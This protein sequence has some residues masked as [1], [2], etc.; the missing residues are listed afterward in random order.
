MKPRQTEISMNSVRRETL[1]Q[2]VMDQIIEL[3]T[4]GQLKPG[5]KLPTEAELTELF[6][7]S[8]PVLREAL[9]SLETMGIIQRKTREGT[10]LADKIGSEPFSIMLAI[11]IGDTQSILEA[12]MALEL[13]LVTLAADKITDKQLAELEK[14]LD[15]TAKNPADYLQFD[16]QFHSLI[17]YSANNPA[18][19]GLV[20][21]LLRI[22]D[23]TLKLVPPI[24]R[25]YA[26]TLEQH[27]EILSALKNRDPIAAYR[28]MFHHLNYVRVK[29]VN[30]L[31]RGS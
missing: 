13:G 16:R 14:C 22:F 3:L 15:L 10:F 19:E 28:S 26:V 9:S 4:H 7:V 27:Y 1:S 24:Q 21:P 29:V 6:L 5:D 20:D 31:R 18:L 17:A 25:N 12:R 8:R 11:S 23:R 30:Q 2:Q